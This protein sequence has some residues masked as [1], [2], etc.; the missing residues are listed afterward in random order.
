MGWVLAGPGPVPVHKPSLWFKS[1]KFEDLGFLSLYGGPSVSPAGRNPQR[2]KILDFL[3][4][5]GGSSLPRAGRNP[6]KIKALILLSLYR[7]PLFPPAI[8]NLQKLKVLDLLRNHG[9]P[10]LLQQVEVLVVAPGGS[11]SSTKMKVM[12]VEPLWRTVVASSKSKS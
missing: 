9:R 5:S 11:K 3:S 4:L 2:L 7:R 6:Q 1:S 8:R 12:S 10:S